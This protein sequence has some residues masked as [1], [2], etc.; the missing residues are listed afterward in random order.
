[1]IAE[2]HF[3]YTRLIFGFLPQLLGWNAVVLFKRLL[4]LQTSYVSKI[5]IGR[6]GFD[7]LPRQPI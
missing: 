3:H 2:W 6:G 7:L 1:V 5:G 4:F